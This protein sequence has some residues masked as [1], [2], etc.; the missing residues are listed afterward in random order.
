METDIRAT[1]VDSCWAAKGTGPHPHL[2][3][4]WRELGHHTGAV[5]TVQAQ[6]AIFLLQVGQH[7]AE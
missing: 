7:M 2:L 3:V 4:G 1:G 5:S 6:A